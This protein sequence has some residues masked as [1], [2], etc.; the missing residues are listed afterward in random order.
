MH[1]RYGTCKDSP[2]YMVSGGACEVELTARHGS[3]TVRRCW[4]RAL[5]L[6]WHC[7]YYKQAAL[8]S[9]NTGC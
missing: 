2:T 6:L 5:L 7:A 1:V 9:T 4:K 8:T 3:T